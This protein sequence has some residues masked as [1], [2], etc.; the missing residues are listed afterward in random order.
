MAETSAP[1]LLVIDGNS[2][3]NRAFYGVRPLTN[4]S[5]KR[6]EALFG[7]LNMILPQIEKRQPTHLAAAFDLHAPTFR[8][9]LYDAYKAG[10]HPTP[11]ELREQIEAAKPLLRALG[12]RIFE[13]EG[14]EADDF[15]GSLAA[16]AER[17]GGESFLFTGDRD[18]LQL[19]SEKTKVLLAKTGETVLFDR[20]TFKDTYG[21]WPEQYLDVKALMGDS[22]DNIPGVPGI[23]EK[24]AF[25]LVAAYG[26]MDALYEALEQGNAPDVKAGQAKKLLE[27]RESGELSRTLAKISREAPIGSLGEAE[28]LPID[29]AEAL[30]ILTELNFS[31][32]IARLGLDKGETPAPS[33]RE[34]PPAEYLP[35][36]L[37][38]EG[39]GRCYGLS[40]CGEEL[41]LWDEEAESGIVL[42]ISDGLRDFL[43]SNLFTVY[44]SKALRDVLP[45]LCLRFDCMLACWMLQPDAPGDKEGA[46]AH[47]VLQYLGLALDEEKIFADPRIFC[48]LREELAAKLEETGQKALYE[49]VEL[50]LSCLLWRM[51]RAGALVDTEGLRRFG[52]RLEEIAADLEKQIYELAGH[53]FNINS[54]KQLGVVLF[55]EMGIPGGKKTKTGYSTGA[56]ELE[57]LA[58]YCPIIPLI[59]D[60]RQAVK[61]RSTY[62]VA[63]CD[64][65]DEEGRVHTRYRQTGTATGRLSS[66]EPNL[67]N[68]PVRTELGREFRKFFKAPEGC[69]LVDADYSQIELRVLAALSGDEN[70][71]AAF[72]SGVDIHRVTASQVFRTPLE[73]V[74]PDLRGKA[75][76]VNFGIVYGISDYSLSQDIHVTKRQAGEY[77]AAYEQTYS[78]ITDFLKKT[79]EQAKEDGFVTTAFGRRRYIPELRSGKAMLRAFGERVARNSPIQGTAADVIKIAMLRVDARLR[80]EDLRARLILQIHDELIVEAPEAEAG[81]VAA[82]LREE[83]EGAWETAVPFS[84]EVNTGNSW[85]ECK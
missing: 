40:I 66:A 71:T 83:M 45:E 27:G 33:G 17:A 21:V 49:N 81:K 73:Q 9:T 62:A 12:V 50:P 78:G 63:L 24:S 18:S 8:H 11:P 53:P 70:M 47:A 3:L 69:V 36:M 77:I 25:A 51:E 65:A 48:L 80:A 55:E 59:F 35:A 42:P 38:P 85:Y 1:R 5:G 67:Q 68:I 82:I 14:W 10:R 30:R 16:A 64:A 72:L 23:G 22:S 52:D 19:I 31:S 57:K 37:P 61:L 56:D 46:A 6:T 4:A 79:V 58:P 29:R 39:Q 32:M 7:M 13:A 76:A 20:E 84:V 41:R 75:K 2:I 74:T 26:G 44:D 34:L 28:R 43:G 54:P 15:L 60:Y